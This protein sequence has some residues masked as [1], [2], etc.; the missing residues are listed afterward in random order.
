VKRVAS[1]LFAAT[2]GAALLSGACGASVPSVIRDELDRAPR[3]VATVVFFTDFQCP[4]CRRTHAA[5][6]RVLAERPGRVRVVLRHVPLRMH[7]DAP[8]AARAAICGEAHGANPELVHALFQASDLGDAACEELAV[9][10]G[11]AREAYRRCITDPATEARIRSDTAMLDAVG[12]DGVPI[13]YVG[14]ERL[15]GAQS[16]RTLAAAIDRALVEAPARD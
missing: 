15:E 11:A 4:F 16:P 3:G 13:L 14:R 12:G 7:P 6:E 8:S 10:H 5:L 2:F 1:V 9:E